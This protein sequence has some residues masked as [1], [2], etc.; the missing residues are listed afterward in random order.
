[1]SVFYEF[2]KII[3]Q[4]VY[5]YP[6]TPLGSQLRQNYYLHK[7]RKCGNSLI[8]F[9]HV[10][11]E[12]P[13]NITIG[14]NISVNRGCLIDASG[15]DISLGNNIL[16]GPNTVLRAAGH[17]FTERD[18]PIRNQNHTRGIIVIE[19]DIWLGANITIL[20]NV[21]IGKGSVIGAGAVVTKDI[22]PYSIAVGVPCKKI[23]TRED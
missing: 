12:S 2:K 15:G 14:N 21:T 11:I 1:M 4:F 6:T 19:D 17:I 23:K 22:E 3:Q 13:E 5:L 20:P 16:I 9:T 18:T 8:L 7:F 10:H